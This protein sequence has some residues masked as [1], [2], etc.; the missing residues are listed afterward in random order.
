MPQGVRI[1]KT[2]FSYP[3]DSMDGQVVL[4]VKKHGFTDQEVALPADQDSDQNVKLVKVASRTPKPQ[5][6]GS[7]SSTPTGTGTLDPFDKLK[8][9]GN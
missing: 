9:R 5:D 1:G 7:G 2:P 6:A 8:K 4:I 3:M